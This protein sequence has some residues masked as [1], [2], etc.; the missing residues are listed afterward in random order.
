MRALRHV[1]T[2]GWLALLLAGSLHSEVKVLKNF[3]LIDGS[4]RP[5]MGSYS[6]IID[7]GRVRWVGPVGQLKAPGSAEVVDLAG[8]Y[9]MPGIINLHGHIGNT[10]DLKQD[11]SF[12]T[13]ENIEKNLNTYASY[14][15]TT[16]LSMGTDQD[17]I[18][19]I[20]DEQRAGRPSSTRVYTAGQGMVFKGGYG[21]LA[22]VNSGIATVS[23]VE[24]AVAA[25]AAKKVDI[26]KLWMDDHLGTQ[27]KMPYDIGKAII[28]SA[29]RHH[30]SVAAHIFYLQDAKQLVEYGV[31]GL[32]H[33]VRDKLVD[34]A[35]VD[36]MKKH[37]VWQMAP[38]LSREASM[39]IYGQPPP[40]ADMAF[41][42]RGVPA[43]VVNTLKSPAY[44]KT[45]RS[46]P[47]F[48]RYRGFFETAKRNLKT[49]ADAGVKYGFGTDTGPPGR[50]PGYFE[51]WEMELM[52]EAGL[53]PMQVITAATRNSAEFLGAKDLG[54]LEPTKW[55][56]LVVLE[57]N[58]LDD[59]KN[60]R[61]ISAVYIAGNKVH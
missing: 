40:F 60:T 14:G 55:A 57:R 24:P 4:G 23:E 58:P 6:M 32:A 19:K 2:T 3:T 48:D 5:P 37:A 28:D 50:F 59:I 20:R 26:I 47:E 11:A 39:F 42:R 34:P 46:D 18:F 22:G 36:S 1:R 52:V 27:K 10:V 45:I 21:G 25:Q 33:S 51:H 15:V 31:N 12:F 41:F 54:T 49:L 9:V 17:L 7:H 61:T 53:T 35:M 56:D 30:L 44:Q 13:R 43:N 38:T 16:V 8:K 29:H